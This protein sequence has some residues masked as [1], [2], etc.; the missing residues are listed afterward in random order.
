[1]TT[2]AREKGWIDVPSAA[3]SMRQ[4][5]VGRGVRAPESQK[6]LEVSLEPAGPPSRCSRST[7]PPKRPVQR[8]PR[9]PD[10][11]RCSNRFN[12][13]EYKSRSSMLNIDGPPENSSDL[14]RAPGARSIGEEFSGGPSIVHH[15]QQCENAR[16]S[17]SCC[18]FWDPE[19]KEVL[20]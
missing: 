5:G 7:P 8:A 16:F 6:E 12:R 2:C 14:E 9:T 4:T 20:E 11:K 17:H 19:S 3:Q 18:T 10:P 13:F 15:F 1:M